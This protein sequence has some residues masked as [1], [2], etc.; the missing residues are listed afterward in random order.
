MTLNEAITV[1]KDRLQQMDEL[2]NKTVFDEWAII[3]VEGSRGR[4]LT[5]EG[6]RRE[7]FTHS[8]PAEVKA[9]GPELLKSS[10]IPADMRPGR[11]STPTSSSA[12]RCS[13]SATTP[14]SP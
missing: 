12:D 13:S 9:F 1:I 3:R 6:Q 2:Y 4:I 5:Y 14:R 7:D 8:F 10:Q 11:T